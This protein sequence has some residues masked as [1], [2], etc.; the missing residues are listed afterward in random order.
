MAT[1][2]CIESAVEQCSVCLSKDSEVLIDSVSEQKFSHSETLVTQIKYCF[3]SGNINVQSI[4][5]I[6]ISEGPGSYTGLRVG[7]SVAKG[8]CYSLN[9]PLIAINTLEII[10][11][12]FRDSPIIISTVDARRNEAYVA[13]FG[14]GL[15]P[16][17]DP[18][19]HIFGPESFRSY[20]GQKGVIVCGTAA[21]KASPLM[22]IGSFEYHPTSPQARDMA[23]LATSL[24]EKST[25]V[26]TAYFEPNY[27][28]PPNITTAKKKLIL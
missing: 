5:A 4:D 6:A 15:K 12:P 26:D 19:P 1:I 11:F 10:A 9:K 3:D 7:A 8:M 17:E 18:T 16:I 28:K 20:L 27:I 25:F 22:D 2:L 21:A 23:H 13:I 24:F 14:K